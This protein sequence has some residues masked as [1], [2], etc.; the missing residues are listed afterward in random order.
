[1]KALYLL[2][3]QHHTDNS[4][5]KNLRVA[6][7]KHLEE[8]AVFLSSLTITFQSISSQI[9]EDRLSQ[10]IDKF[11]DKLTQLCMIVLFLKLKTIK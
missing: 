2:E 5:V 11:H 1:M 9:N 7:I 8:H 3:S 10:L 4:E 6:N